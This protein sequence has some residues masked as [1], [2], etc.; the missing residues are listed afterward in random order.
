MNMLNI[1]PSDVSLL[2]PVSE[3]DALEFLKENTEVILRVSA[4]EFFGV[5]NV[6]E[7]ESK[8]ALKEKGVYSTWELYID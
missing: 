8:K 5:D 6:E 2:T 3:K 4:R 1:E 7:Y